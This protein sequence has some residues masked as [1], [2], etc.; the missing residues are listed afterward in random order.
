MW[1]F[2]SCLS[3]EEV[4]FI[5]FNLRVV[6]D[7]HVSF[8]CLFSWQTW[9]T[10]E[11]LPELLLDGAA[12]GEWLKEHQEG[13]ER[14]LQTVALSLVSFKMSVFVFQQSWPTSWIRRTN[15]NFPSALWLCRGWVS[16]YCWLFNLVFFCCCF[17]FFFWLHILHF[18][19]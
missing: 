2:S 12:V 4:F 10:L 14:D 3:N 6:E 15:A 9:F 7:V 5:F 18:V 13:G 1:C 19:L 8:W 16:L 17:L 11:V